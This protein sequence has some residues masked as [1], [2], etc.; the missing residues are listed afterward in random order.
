[1]TLG[2][3]SAARGLRKTQRG[4]IGRIK[5]IDSQARSSGKRYPTQPIYQF[6]IYRCTVQR[7]HARRGGK[8]VLPVTA[9]RS[10]FEAGGGIVLCMSQLNLSARAYTQHC[11]VVSSSYPAPSQIWR[12][13]RRYKPR[14]WRRR[15]NTVRKSWWGKRGFKS[16]SGDMAL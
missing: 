3:R 11:V 14:I 12:G 7:R 2:D 8:A 10:E 6:P 13:V 4:S 1:M 9:R 16:L 5:R 15:C